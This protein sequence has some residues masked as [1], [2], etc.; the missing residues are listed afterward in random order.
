M[1]HL[2]ESIHLFTQTPTAAVQVYYKMESL[3]SFVKKIEFVSKVF[4]LQPKR[5]TTNPPPRNKLY[6]I[7]FV[8]V[9][10]RIITEW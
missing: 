1:Q 5:A 10:K 7:N 6:E 8:A 9:D 2:H 3:E 4:A